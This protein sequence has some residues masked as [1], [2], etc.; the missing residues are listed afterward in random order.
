MKNLFLSIY[1]VACVFMAGTAH[2]TALAPSI[3]EIEASQGEVAQ[4]MFQIINT[5]AAEQVYYLG[6]L[7]FEASEDGSSPEFIPFDEDHEGLPEWIQFPVR[8]VRVP[9]RTSVDVPFTISVPMDVVAGSY[10]AAVTVSKAPSDVVAT[11]G[12]I[13]EAKTAVLVLLTVSGETRA[14]A[15]LLDFTSSKSSASLAGTYQF[16]IQNQ[17]NVHIQP[18]GTVRF[19]DVLGRTIL[20]VDAN[21]DGS[22]VLPGS[23]RTFE[24]DVS[25][26]DAP[27]ALGP[28]NATLAITY[29]DGVSLKSTMTFW[30]V[31]WKVLGSLVGS[32]LVLLILFKYLRSSN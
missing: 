15:Q 18:K 1:F 23:T 7:K 26:E 3:L 6:V 30:I 17:G 22:R 28:V 16:R 9:S 24:V 21:Q 2:A 32:L 13:I 27:F 10:F 12:A 29:A 25:E 19:S 4:Q 8:E 14:Q 11:N 31:S 20:E 5:E